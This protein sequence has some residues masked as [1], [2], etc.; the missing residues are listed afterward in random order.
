MCDVCLSPGACCRRIFLSGG[1]P[2]ERL[3]DPMSHERAEHLAMRFGLPFVPGA[4]LEDGRWQW[5]C[6]H[7]D[8]NGRCGIYDQRP[9]VCRIYR[10]GSDALC[11]HY[12][13]RPSADERIAELLAE[14][15]ALEERD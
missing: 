2:G 13:P 12:W 10:P 7:L 14:A 11:V 4:Q 5:A 8:S 9:E 6:Y 15:E 1:A 3:E